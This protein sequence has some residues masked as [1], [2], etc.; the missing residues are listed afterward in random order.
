MTRK[1]M[2]IVSFLA[3]SL[4]LFGCGGKTLSK[5]LK[6][7]N[8]DEKKI[9][10]TLIDYE[11]AYNAHD[12][13]KLLS[14]FSSDAKLMPCGEMGSQVSKIDY[15]K[16]FPGKWSS[17]PKYV[18]SNPVVTTMENKANLKSTLVSGGWTTD[19]RIMMI[20]E[21]GNWLIQE[22]SYSNPR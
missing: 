2:I 3:I 4:F 14:F 8:A 15:A 20:K 19:Y 16:R 12:K 13:T 9:I 17:Y 1:M 6:A 18:F 21:N 7:K 5:D 22:T 11:Q 10:E